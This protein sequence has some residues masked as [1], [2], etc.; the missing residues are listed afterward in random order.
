MKPDI[1]ID[2]SGVIR[3][4]K[5]GCLTE[6][7]YVLR[8][9]TCRECRAVLFTDAAGRERRAVRKVK[10]ADAITYFEC[11]VCSARFALPRREAP[12]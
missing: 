5:G 4:P 10:T 9:V 7:D 8:P 1:D 12:L 6:W 11:R 2:F 3:V